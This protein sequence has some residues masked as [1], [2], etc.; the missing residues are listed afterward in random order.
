MK[1]QPFGEIADGL[2][3][4]GGILLVLRPSTSTLLILLVV[5]ETA[6]EDEFEVS[7]LLTLLVRLTFSLSDLHDN[8]SPFKS[9]ICSTVFLH[10][11]ADTTK[12]C[13]IS[14]AFCQSNDS[15]QM[16][17]E[18]VCTR[19]CGMFRLGKGQ[20]ETTLQRRVNL[21]VGGRDVMHRLQFVFCLSKVFCWSLVLLLLPWYLISKLA[22]ILDLSYMQSMRWVW[23][24]VWSP[25][26][27]LRQCL[28][29]L[30]SK[31]PQ[32]DDSQIQALKVARH[33]ERES[34]CMCR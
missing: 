8:C 6:G 31:L 23:E 27:C 15:T 1:A 19:P 22:L 4:G 30:P 26:H 20:I 9:A 32:I 25:T 12:T 13:K 11:Y 24:M 7:S 3:F 5:L 21:C 17:E 14:G 10:I 28:E 2:T 29:L 33:F 16:L 34:S 18:F